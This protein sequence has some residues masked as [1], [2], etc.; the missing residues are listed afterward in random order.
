[1]VDGDS[2]EIQSGGAMRSRDKD[3][4]EGKARLLND[5]HLYS[6]T[7]AGPTPS[8]GFQK[9]SQLSKPMTGASQAS[10]GPLNR[11][12][13]SSLIA[14]LATTRRLRRGAQVG[15]RGPRE[16]LPRRARRCAPPFSTS[17]S[18]PHLVASS[19]TLCS[20]LRAVISDD[21]LAIKVEP[22][23]QNDQDPCPSSLLLR[24]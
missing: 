10:L 24:A 17:P 4:E 20:S 8:S 6:A 19:L 2:C 12:P 18:P 23:V 3:E 5:D 16:H 1:M 7:A 21:Q 9:L 22:E 14:A 11:S 15:A 13:S